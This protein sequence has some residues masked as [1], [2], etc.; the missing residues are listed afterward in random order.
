M[1]LVELNKIVPNDILPSFN[2][3]RLKEVWKFV[4]Y[5]NKLTQKITKDNLIK[6]EVSVEKFLEK[7]GD[8]TIEKKLEV[9]KSLVHFTLPE[10][11]ILLIDEIV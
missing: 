8:N 3:G 7:Y 4:G 6:E 1:L 10:D 9:F 2:I 5:Y 11:I